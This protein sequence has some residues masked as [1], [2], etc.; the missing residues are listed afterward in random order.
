MRII[1]GSGISGLYIGYQLLEKG[2]K[3][4][5]ILEKSNRI[6]GRILTKDNL[7]L[8]ASIFHSKQNNIMRLIYK[9]GLDKKLIELKS[10]KDTLY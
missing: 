7:E 6:G 9:L 1:I 5:I 10:G 8:G 3:D 2:I 4:F